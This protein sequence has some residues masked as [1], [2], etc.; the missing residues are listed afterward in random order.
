VGKILPCPFCG[1][2]LENET[3]ESEPYKWFEGYY[4]HPEKDDC[5]FDN[6]EFDG[7]P[8]LWQKRV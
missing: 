5:P 6:F 2:E 7:L 8:L 1:L 4:V 3:D